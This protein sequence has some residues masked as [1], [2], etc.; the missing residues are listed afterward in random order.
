M[1]DI[2]SQL[3]KL[4]D[5]LR[6]H[7][8]R[9]YVLDDPEISDSAYDRLLRELQALEQQHPEL[10]TDDSPT[11]RVGATPLTAFN[12]VKHEMP[13][14]SLG[15]AMNE[16]EFIDFDKR[17]RERLEVEQ[18]TY[19]AEPKL[20]GLAISLLYEHGKFIRAATRGDGYTGEDVTWNVR[21][22]EAIPLK[23]MGKAYPE[24]L[25]V[26]GEVIMT[27]DG[28]EK[29]NQVQR[30]QNA[31]IF[32]N[33]R[34]AAAGSLRQLDPCITATRPLSF[35]SYGMGIVSDDFKIP[36][37]HSKLMQQLQQWGIRINLESKA[38]KGVRSALHY[39]QQLADRRDALAYEI[40]GI[41]YKVDNLSHQQALGF[42]SRAPRWAIAY[43][44]PAHEE[45]TIVEDIDIQ[46][47]R[48]G[49]LT[50]V[51]RL[52]PVFVGGVT[53]SN[54]TL[55]NQ[56]EIERLDIRRGDTVVIRRAGDVIPQ[57]VNVV[58]SKRT[59]KP[60]KYKI[61]DKCPVC[62]SATLRNKD[63]V[64][65]YCTGGL[66][67]EAQRKQA[68]IHFASRKTMN[69]DGLGDKLVMQLVDE[70]LIHDMADLFGLTHQQL[71]GL[72][73]MGDKSAQNLLEA[74]EKAKATT[75]ARFIFALGI[76]D[77]GETTA[78]TLAN[79]FSDL[80]SLKKANIETLLHIP[81]VGPVVAE[82]IVT[83][84]KQKHNRDVIKK[85]L[86]AGIHWPVPEK[87]TAARQTLVGKTFVLTG[88]LTQF[89]RDQ[90]KQALQARGAKVTGSVSKKTDYVVAGEN[91]GSKAVKAEQLGIE[92]LNENALRRLLTN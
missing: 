79:Y 90:A 29:L 1:A 61:P 37:T 33:P 55:H 7:N 11:Q 20:D 85:L 56:D 25:E 18:I 41:V 32:A 26:R 8:Y 4:R 77:V 62:G 87:T 31:K 3:E 21:T 91:A 36:T 82:N 75:F 2:Q 22:I 24:R 60:R 52:K 19:S 47:G 17:A 80:E 72:E 53:V 81:D 27:R 23:L 83:F 46:V 63:E 54:A 34:N 13:M 67:C 38:V 15:N 71:V 76:H 30:K 57:I 28:F 5:E 88:T 14:L 73:R 74:L 40:D 58:H 89:T 68:I 78:R 42:V 69:I 49:A 51:A 43:K 50:P 84:F 86:K 59:G 44:F 10:I 45:M 64:A 9:Y 39:Y 92:I 65:T 66:F 70:G 12:E 16:Q 6:Y 48:T 35:F